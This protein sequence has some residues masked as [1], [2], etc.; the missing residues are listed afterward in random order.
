MQQRLDDE[1]VNEYRKRSKKSRFSLLEKIPKVKIKQENM[2]QCQALLDRVKLLEKMPKNAV[3][4]E[5]GVNQGD[6]SQQILSIC[7]P[8]KLHLIDAWHTERYHDGLSLSVTK[9][10]LKEISSGQIEVNRGLS[11][12]VVDNLPDEYFD[13]IYIDT[14]HDYT[15]TK[16]ELEKYSKKMKKGGVIAGHDYTMGNWGEMYKYG[17]IEA[18]HEFCVNNNWELIFLT[19]DF[20]ENQSFAIRKIIID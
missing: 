20:T 7:Q 16:L 5:I 9:K 8:R 2:A 13:W 14:S 11:T 12:K 6:F 10:F 15:T 1:I 3:V 4:A 18:V 19:V 17:V